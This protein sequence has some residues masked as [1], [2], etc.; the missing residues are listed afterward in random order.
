MEKNKKAIEKT[1]IILENKKAINKSNKS[2][3]ALNESNE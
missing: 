2:T 1:I 3:K